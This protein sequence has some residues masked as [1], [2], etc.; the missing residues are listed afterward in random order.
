MREAGGGSAAGSEIKS[1]LNKWKATRLGNT[2]TASMGLPNEVDD[3]ELEVSISITVSSA[4]M[5]FS[6]T[7]L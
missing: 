1:I 4:E 3:H 5:A 6:P 2:E 7:R